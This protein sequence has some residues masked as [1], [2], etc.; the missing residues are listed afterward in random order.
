MIDY[1]ECI[2]VE[3]TRAWFAAEYP[4]YGHDLAQWV[5]I[6]AARHADDRTTV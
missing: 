6:I 5:D 3:A 2:D 1:L 4:S